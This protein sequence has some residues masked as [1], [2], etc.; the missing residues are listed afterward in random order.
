M[1]QVPTECWSVLH[2]VM[3]HEKDA[4]KI[5]QP[6]LIFLLDSVM[7]YPRL[8]NIS[9]EN[10][11]IHSCDTWHMTLLNLRVFLCRPQLALK[12]KTTPSFFLSV[13][14]LDQLHSPGVLL[15]EAVISFSTFTT[16]TLSL[17]QLLTMPH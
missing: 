14:H 13:L 16:L 1:K 11:Q 3:E 4:I 10:A 7:L 9:E 12:K 6:G 15:P 5:A 17:L 2:G 8:I